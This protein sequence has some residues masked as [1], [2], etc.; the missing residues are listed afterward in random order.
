MQYQD[1]SFFISPV[2]D[3]EGGTAFLPLEGLSTFLREFIVKI[4]YGQIIQVESVFFKRSFIR[5]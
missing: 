5:N 3:W 4:W 2:F 1:R